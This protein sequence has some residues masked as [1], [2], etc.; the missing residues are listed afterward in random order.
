MKNNIFFR[1]GIILFLFTYINNSF[2]QSDSLKTKKIFLFDI[3]EE[4][5]RPVLRKTQMAFKE[6]QRVKADI[7]LIH[8]NTYGGA[9]DAA[10]SIRTVILYSKIPVYVFIDHNA[11]SAGALISIACKKIYMRSASNIGAA[12]V[13]NQSGE[14]MP[15]KYQSYMRS[16]MRSTAEANG[17]DPD[18][19][20]AMVDSRIKIE[21]VNDSGKVLT[22]TTTEA[23][24]HGYCNGEAENIEQLLSKDGIKKYQIIKQEFSFI[25]K[26]ILFLIHPIVSGILIVLIIGGLYFEIQSPGFG[27]PLGICVFGALLYFAPLYLE[28]LA[29]NWEILIFIIGV[30]LVILEIFAIPGFGFV[31]ISGIVLIITG[32]ALSLLDNHGFDF[33]HLSANGLMM[34][35]STVLISIFISILLS[36]YLS[37]KFLTS[38]KFSKLALQT[39]QRKEH[40]FSVA[41]NSYKELIGQ[42]GVS[43]TMLRPVGKVEIHSEIFQATAQ[44]GFIN[45]GENIRVVNYENTQLIVEKA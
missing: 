43:V 9:L 16:L 7:I 19:A 36:F 42:T 32:L 18:I 10:D 31:G 13:V 27:I 17:R 29:A 26:A 37:S 22:F 24:K 5:A 25:D 1:Y 39:I 35:F 23:I 20:Q 3:K 41:E 12:T 44:T 8:M 15:D 21:G 40:G 28:G 38:G 34:A 14:P 45:K 11:A 33:S 6:A 2:C 4:I 30:I